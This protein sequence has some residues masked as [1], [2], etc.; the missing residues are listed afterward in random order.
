MTSLDLLFVCGN[1]LS[2]FPLVCAVILAANETTLHSPHPLWGDNSPKVRVVVVTSIILWSVSLQLTFRVSPI[3]LNKILTCNDSGGV[4]FCTLQLG[5][6]SCNVGN[7]GY[8]GPWFVAQMR[9]YE[10]D[11]LR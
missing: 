11:E 2:F 8:R 9:C 3:V 4:N 5:S 7:R 1:V 10:I 6:E